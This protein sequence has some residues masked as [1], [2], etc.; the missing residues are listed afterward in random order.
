MRQSCIWM[1]SIMA[2]WSHSHSSVLPS[3][4]VST[5]VSALPSSAFVRNCCQMQPAGMGQTTGMPWQLW[6]PGCQLWLVM[7]AAV[8]LV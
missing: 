7:A 3:T 2:A 6:S 8:V 4:S 1:A 5:S